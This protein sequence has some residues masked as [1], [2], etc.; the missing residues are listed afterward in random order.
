MNALL[1]SRHNT[2]I[3]FFLSRA[4]LTK[5]PALVVSPLHP[6]TCPARLMLTD[7]LGE[8][9]HDA[10]AACHIAHVSEDEGFCSA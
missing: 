6:V 9:C 2:G 1:N 5:C 8:R 10:D 7:E 4:K 3:D